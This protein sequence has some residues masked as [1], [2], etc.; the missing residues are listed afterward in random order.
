[1][2]GRDVDPSSGRI[3]VDAVVTLTK[4][5][6]KP[7]NPKQKACL[8]TAC[9]DGLWTRSRLH[10]VGIVDSDVCELC[11][12]GPDTLQH[13]I[14]LCQHP[15]VVAARQLYLKP[16]DFNRMFNRGSPALLCRGLFEHPG[17]EADDPGREGG[18]VTTFFGDHTIMF[19]GDGSWL[20]RYAAIH[21]SCSRIGIEG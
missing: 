8:D 6:S 18:V 9:C 7:L 19:R 12:F 11:G 5:P 2:V 13:R 14:Q 21:G 3:C 16:A 20:P 1:M 15:D 4:P 17:V 10:E